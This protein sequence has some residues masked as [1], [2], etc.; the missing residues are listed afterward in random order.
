MVPDR[1]LLSSTPLQTMSYW[2]ALTSERIHAS[3]AHPSRPAA[4]EKGL[5][6]KSICTPVSSI[7]LEHREVDDPRELEIRSWSVSPSSS[8]ITTRAFAATGSNSSGLADEEH[9]V[10]RL[11]S[12]DAEFVLSIFFAS[13]RLPRSSA[14]KSLTSR[15]RRRSSCS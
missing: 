5:W 3:P 9:R 10:P 11:Q 4:C 2:Y 6:L 15:L 8:P 7:A 12:A 14:T 1:P 13:D